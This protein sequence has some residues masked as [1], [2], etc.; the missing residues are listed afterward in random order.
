MNA[1]PLG[2]RLIAWAAAEESVQ[3]LVLIGSR[4]R[5]VDTLAAAD[6]H[7]D[8]DFQLATSRPELF[9]QGDWLSPLGIEPRAYVRRIGRLGSA[10]KVSV[11][12]DAGEIDLVIM[13]VPLLRGVVALMPGDRWVEAPPARQALTDLS[14][15]VA[16]GY[17]ILK[18]A[19]EF[20]AFYEQVARTVP[21]ARLD[22]AAVREVA[23][24]FV[25]DYVATHRRLERGE[26]CAAQRWLHHQL[27]EANFRLLHEVRRREGSIS[28][29]D[30]RRLERLGD[31]RGAGLIVAATPTAA[32]LR[33]AVEKAA[34]THRQ[35]VAALLGDAWRWPDLAALC[36]GAE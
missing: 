33:A 4:A 28:F 7:S 3:L 25:C 18:G 27:A 22:D 14:T 23:E 35:L 10:E 36:L 13:P 12:T 5:E 19:A 6:R 9:A 32:A 26:F 8:W 16:G 20:A 17:R 1:A 30:A 24:G 31:P 2:D 34:D 15:V 21:T 29:P 11:V